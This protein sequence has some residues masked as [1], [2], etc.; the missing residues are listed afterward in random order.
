VLYQELGTPHYLPE[1]EN[2][3]QWLAKV[4]PLC[5]EM[6]A[7]SPL[8]AQQWGERLLS[9]H[10][11]SVLP[12]LVE[13]TLFA[14]AR[15]PQPTAS[16]TF[17]FAARLESGKG[18]MNLIEAFARVR[19]ELTNISLKMAGAGPQQ[20]AVK[21]R[22]RALGV[23][24]ACDFPGA[25]I[26]PETRSAFMQGLD[27]FVLP[28]L[29]EG[30]PNSIIEAM[31]HGLPVIASE[32]GGIPD[33]ITPETGI[34]VSPGD[35]A[36]LADAMMVLA[37]DP[38]LRLRMGQAARSRY[39]KL[40]SPQAVLPTLVDTYRSVAMRNCRAVMAPAQPL[41]HPWIEAAQE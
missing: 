7:L 33:L 3:Y 24:N 4:V 21:A 6:A 37:L 39:E 19:L 25:Y 13:D 28:T 18:P 1:L 8:L 41:A 10:P 40:F 23:L 20:D 31:A 11:V 5:S 17:G 34:L 16:M 29:A 2:H 12:L 15:P 32:V 27:V 9:S 22:A 38:E 35:T 30:T 36:A 26:S 14:D